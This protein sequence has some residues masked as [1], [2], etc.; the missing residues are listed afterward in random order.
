MI[1]S[2]E[3]MGDT[4]NA[5]ANVTEYTSTH[6]TSSTTSE[7]ST[8]GWHDAAMHLDG[9]RVLT[10]RGGCT[11]SDTSGAL[12]LSTVTEHVS[13]CCSTAEWC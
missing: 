10:A 7:S 6:L 13:H 2:E 12:F 5:V 11:T 1:L 8:R 9:V 4:A 3:S